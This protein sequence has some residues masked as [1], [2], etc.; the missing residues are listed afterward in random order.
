MREVWGRVLSYIACGGL[1]TY[2]FGSGEVARHGRRGVVVFAWEVVAL[3]LFDV[4]RVKFGWPG[5]AF[6]PVIV[7]LAAVKAVLIIRALREPARLS[8]RR[9]RN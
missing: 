4:L 3:V 1:F 2:F 8:R 7:G 9:A 6:A 5:Y